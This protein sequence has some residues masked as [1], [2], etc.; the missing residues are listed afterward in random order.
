MIDMMTRQA[1]RTTAFESDVD[2]WLAVTRR[3]HAAD[4]A[5]LYS[6]RTT[7]VYCR[8]SCASRAARRDNVRFHAT[9]EAAEQA[10]FRPC[11]RCRPREAG[12]AQRRATAIA[13]A[14][15]VVAQ[16]QASPTLDELAA[17]AGMSRFHFQRV[18]KMICGVTPKAYVDAHRARRV[19]EE[20]GATATVTQAIYRAGFNS[21]APFYAAAEKRLGMTPTAY[22]RGGAGSTVRFAI[23]E[24]SLG[25]ILVAATDRGICAMTLGD[26]PEVLIRELADRFP[27]AQLVGGD[28]DFER[29][30]A[31]AI[32]LVEA[33]GSDADLPLDVRGTAFQQR[34]WQALREIPAGT[35]TNYA[36][37]ARRVGDPNA[38]RAVARACASNPIAV[39]IPCH[40][41]VRTDGALSGYRWGVGRKWTLLEREARR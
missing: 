28:A 2:R 37:L 23:G 13:R 4:G 29:L 17:A 8:P 25:S 39:A 30:V 27:R 19:H 24:C 1:Q 10:G 31:G 5:F 21:N 33:P 12:L 14:C 18:F 40:R 34:V 26:D 15:R 35:V 6:V 9:C 38:T 41:V 22:R 20:L 11:K 3:D 32:G 36:E 7:G 16:A